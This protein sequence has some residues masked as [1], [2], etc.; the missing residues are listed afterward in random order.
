MVASLQLAR[1]EALKR[2][3]PV[4]VCAS[5]DASTCA[6]IPWNKGWM[7]FA[8][9][10]GDGSRQGTETIIHLEE[11]MRGRVNV[12]LPANQPLQNSLTYLPTG[13]PNLVGLAAAGV[14]VL[15]DDRQSNN[16]GRVIVISQTGRPLAA[17]AKDRS[18]LGVTLCE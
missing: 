3:T 12:T 1:S 5:L 16:Y 14:M 18:D 13:F 2:R 9:D 6:D 10:D 11:E 4:T 17:T 7:V 15:C 8:D